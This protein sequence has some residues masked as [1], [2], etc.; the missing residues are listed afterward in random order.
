[1][2]VYASDETETEIDKVELF[3]SDVNKVAPVEAQPLEEEEKEEKEEEASE[4]DEFSQKQPVQTQAVSDENK[5]IPLPDD[6][7]ALF[8]LL[9][10]APLRKR[11]TTYWESRVISVLY[12]S[13]EACNRIMKNR[14]YNFEAVYHSFNIAGLS[15][16]RVLEAL[17]RRSEKSLDV[18]GLPTVKVLLLHHWETHG[19]R[20]HLQ[21]TAMHGFFVI[22]FSL[23]AYLFPQLVVG[24]ANQVA[25]AIFLQV[26]VIWNLAWIIFQE[27]YAIRD[28]LFVGLVYPIYD[29]GSY[30]LACSCIGFCM[31]LPR[32]CLFPF[33]YIGFNYFKDYWN[34][35]D[36]GYILCGVIGISLR[37]IHWGETDTSA[38]Y[39]AV[40]SIFVWLKLLYYMRPF[41]SSG[42]LSKF[43]FFFFAFLFFCSLLIL[44]VF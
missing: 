27:I 10:N 17:C 40:A 24:N 26:L 32:S 35:V 2:K 38:C 34:I 37:T 4:E 43:F 18:F 1:M 42:P 25:A 15:H 5:A 3:A 20:V 14:K 41:R 36:F 19:K 29:A 44:F 21:L 22:S 28:V 9:G 39:L 13:T 7:D 8:A 12:S 6:D 30:L 16:G 23:Y 11:D 33:R 31:V